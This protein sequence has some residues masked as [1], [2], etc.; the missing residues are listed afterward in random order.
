MAYPIMFRIKTE[1][2][3]TKMA[4][5]YLCVTRIRAMTNEG[6]RLIGRTGRLAQKIYLELK[7]VGMKD[8]VVT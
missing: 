7:G 5:L 2:F 6:D 4:A 3:I 1:L 8:Q